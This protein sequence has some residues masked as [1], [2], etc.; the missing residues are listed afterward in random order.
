VILKSFCSV[1]TESC[2]EEAAVLIFSIRE[3]Y[4][5]PVFLLCDTPTK[6]YIEMFDWSGIEYKVEADSEGLAKAANKVKNINAANE[7]HSAS[8]ILLKMDC[9][10][11]AIREAGNSLF[12]D[13]DIIISKP[14]H[15]DICLSCDVMLSQHHHPTNVYNQNSKF[16]AFNAGYV[17]ARSSQVASVWRDIF[18]NR[19]TF[20]EQQGMIWFFEYFNVGLFDE[21]HNFGLSRFS[22]ETFAGDMMLKEPTNKFW[23]AKSY[24]FHTDEKT[25]SSADKGLRLAYSRLSQLLKPCLPEKIKDFIKNPTVSSKESSIETTKTVD[26]WGNCEA[27][28]SKSHPDGKFNLGHQPALKTHRGGWLKVLEAMEPLHNKNGVYCETFVESVFDWFRFKN[29][30]SNHIPIREPWVGFIHNPHSMP[31]WYK[32]AWDGNGDK[33]F[34]ESL[35]SCIGI[36]TMSEY[37]AQG[38]RERYPGKTFESILHPY[39]NEDVLKWKGHLKQLVSVGWWLR[40]QTSIYTVPVP[41]GWSKVKLWPYKKDSKPIEYVTERLNLEVNQLN[42]QLPEIN[43]LYN[44]S[45][46]DYDTLLCNSVVLLDL[47]DTSANNT[48]LECIQREVPIIVKNHPAVREYL[49]DSYPLYFNDLS[50]VSSLLSRVDEASEYLSDLRKSGRFTMNRFIE[51]VKQSEIYRKA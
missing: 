49:G 8:K 12:V 13:A 38:L 11:W 41:D 45:N 46:D 20:Y 47:W 21:T 51:E 16:G 27:I 1:A 24:H 10:E 36:Y 42:I 23:D 33:L 29:E 2:K 37:H 40:K 30:K 7:F 34:E 15:E 17:W 22:K 3:H 25:Y 39:P 14:I 35:E 5:L 44:L 28:F 32:P 48:V 50:E 9:F 4:D 19:S 31:D 6:E 18:L 43:H 26:D